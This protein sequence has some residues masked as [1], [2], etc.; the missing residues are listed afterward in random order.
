MK[1]PKKAYPEDAIAEIRQIREEIVA[2]HGYD[3]HAICVAAMQRQKAAGRKVVNL[4][5]RPRRR[6]VLTA[7]R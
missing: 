1:T 7:A 6:A 5:N 3:L 2:E 4:T